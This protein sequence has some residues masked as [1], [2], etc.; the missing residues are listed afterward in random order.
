MKTNP[1]KIINAL[2]S[3]ITRL[4]TLL[5][6]NDAFKQQQAVNA[7][8]AIPSDANGFDYQFMAEQMAPAPLQDLGLDYNFGGDDL[9]QQLEEANARINDLELLVAGGSN[10]LRQ[11][12]ALT[13]DQSVGDDGSNGS[14]GAPT[15]GSLGLGTMAYQNSDNIIATLISMS[16]GNSNT[17]SLSAADM[18]GSS[19]VIKFRPISVCG[20]T[21][22][23]LCSQTY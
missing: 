22:L 4:E 9:A 11:D 21:I 12:D 16:L 3:R 19:K 2:T 14:G 20:G 18:V 6:D 1:T 15:A 17:V 23:V 5:T 13:A 7:S 8:G 10:D